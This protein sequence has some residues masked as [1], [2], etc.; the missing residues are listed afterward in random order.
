MRTFNLG[1]GQCGRYV[2]YEMYKQMSQPRYLPIFDQFD[3]FTGDF[4]QITHKD[5]L[6]RA[7]VTYIKEKE[8]HHR[9]L[10]TQTGGGVGGLWF[11]SKE[12]AKQEFSKFYESI[13]GIYP[14]DSS[15]FN[16]V[17]SGGGGTGCGTGPTF[18][19]LI[20]E[21]VQEKWKK[22]KKFEETIFFSTLVLPF[23]GESAKY[24]ITESNSAAAIGRYMES[25]AHS[26]FLMDN[27]TVDEIKERD[28]ISGL[29]REIA[30][31]WIAQWWIWL[32]AASTEDPSILTYEVSFE[33]ADMRRHFYNGDKPGIIIPCYKEYSIE[34]FTKGNFTL[35]GLI[36]KTLQNYLLTNCLI[37]KFR[38]I[39]IFII[40]PMRLKEKLQPILP[41]SH[42]IGAWLTDTFDH[43]D[44]FVSY[45]HHDTPTNTLKIVAFLSDPYIPIFVDYYNKFKK[46]VYSKND[47][48]HMIRRAAP[49]HVSKNELQYFVEEGRSEYL[50]AFEKYEKFLKKEKY[51]LEGS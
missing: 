16:F 21:K 41:E 40:I 43:E 50:K 28:K 32:T 12:V 36:A 34:Y 14:F 5:E 33:T 8:I 38:S 39:V 17:H 6:E 26:V 3:F 22:E 25:K 35:Y 10:S 31:R 7:G 4:E 46:V 48:E 42:K 24:P 49:R 2:T 1:L 19:D 11:V 37:E 15:V 45:I 23:E 20:Y 51:E 30:N 18:L 44:H 29:S 47:L 27:S 13:E 9:S